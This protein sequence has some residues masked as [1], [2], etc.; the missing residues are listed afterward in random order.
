MLL[1]LVTGSFHNG[2]VFRPLATKA[3]LELRS[4][5]GSHFSSLGCSPLLDHADGLQATYAD[6]AT[7]AGLVGSWVR[8]STGRS[9]SS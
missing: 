3:G 5:S 7:I 6:M 1:L 8:T 2:E 9:P 4:R